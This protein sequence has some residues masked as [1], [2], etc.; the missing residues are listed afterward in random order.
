M[1]VEGTGFEL[2]WKSGKIQ[3]NDYIAFEQ[4]LYARKHIGLQMKGEQSLW[5]KPHYQ[6]LLAQVQACPI[7]GKMAVKTFA[8]TTYLE[9]PHG[10]PYDW[11][12]SHVKYSIEQGVPLKYKE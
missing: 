1:P 4:V 9:R 10:Y 8:I 6:R 7:Y 12:R 11:V 5:N 2:L 3:I